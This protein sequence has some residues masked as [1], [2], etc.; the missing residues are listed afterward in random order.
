MTCAMCECVHFHLRW[1]A[2]TKHSKEIPGGVMKSS[3]L[4]WKSQW[5]AFLP[6]WQYTFTS[7]ARAANLLNNI[8]ILNPSC[9]QWHQGF[10]LS[11]G[12]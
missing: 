11:N 6:L 12:Q 2:F 9:L 7:P 3:C 1:A 4:L 5:N 10:A 8:I